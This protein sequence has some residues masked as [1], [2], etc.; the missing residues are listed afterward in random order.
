M[1]V[2]AGM[3]C[4][5]S[6]C[7]WAAFALPERQG[8]CEGPRQALGQCPLFDAIVMQSVQSTPGLAYLK[9]G[10]GFSVPPVYDEASG[11]PFPFTHGHAG[12][13]VSRD[14]NPV[15]KTF[16]E[17]DASSHPPMSGVQ[18]LSDGD[19]FCDTLANF[20][21][22]V[23]LIP[24]ADNMCY[25]PPTELTACTDLGQAWGACR[26]RMCVCVRV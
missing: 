18:G 24:E 8:D 16:R 20:G 5:K 26:L 14:G 3:A 7:D 1:Y 21:G 19:Q 25:L 9:P 4:F 17:D 13:C 11:E 15:C 10:I 23:L 2:Y 22:R 12:R 6:E